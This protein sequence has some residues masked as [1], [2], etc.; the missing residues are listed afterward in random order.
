MN[1]EIKYN[2]PYRFRFLG[3]LIKYHVMQLLPERTQTIMMV[4]NGGP[5]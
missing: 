2:Y 1:K 5:T 4:R 3:E